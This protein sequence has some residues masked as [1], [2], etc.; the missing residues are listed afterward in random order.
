MVGS[1]LIGGWIA[2]AAFWIVIAIAAEGARY[3][4]TAIFIGLWL[5]G[6]AAARSA[7]F[8][9]AWFMPYVAALDIALVLIVFKSDIRLT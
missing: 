6:Y 2:H 4:L 8:G 9:A 5:I 1:A 3:R 7:A